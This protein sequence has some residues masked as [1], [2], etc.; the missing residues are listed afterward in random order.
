[1][2]NVDTVADAD[3]GNEDDEDN[4]NPEDEDEEEVTEEVVVTIIDQSLP[5]T[6]RAGRRCTTYQNRNFYGDSD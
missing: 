3:S 6:T 4:D 1:M 2:K 5:T